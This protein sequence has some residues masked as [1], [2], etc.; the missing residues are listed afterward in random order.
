[1]TNTIQHLGKLFNL[2][3]HLAG[4]DGVKVTVAGDVEIHHGV[5]GSKFGSYI[6]SSMDVITLWILQDCGLLK[7]N[8]FK[9]SQQNLDGLVKELKIPTALDS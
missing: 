9:K 5:S 3:E 4:T 6:Q 8:I 1:M 2:K 7:V